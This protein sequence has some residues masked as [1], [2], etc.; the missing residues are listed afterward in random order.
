MIAN[1]R[2]YSV[3]AE[4]KA[5]WRTLLAWVIARAG[6]ALEIIDYDPPAPMAALWAR[7]DLGCAM[8]CGLPASL[9]VPAPRL[10]AAPVPSPSRYRGQACYMTDIAVR[11]DSS[12]GSLEDTFGGI[13]GFTVADSQS[14]YFALRYHLWPLQRQHGGA[15]Y[16]SAIGGLLN[17]RGVIDAL[18]AGTIDVGPLDSYSHDLLRHLEP[19]YAQQVRI[20]ASSAATPMPPFV[21]T[22]DLDDDAIELLRTAFRAA[23]QHD[24]LAGTRAQLLLAGFAFPQ[25]ADYVP[26]RQ[27]RDALIAAPEL[28]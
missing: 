28:W 15:L 23:A 20:V 9:R 13:V 14:G 12:F 2:M 24:D 27:R 11:A 18:V 22:A 7:D 17:A 21:A 25:P 19:D 8:M 16:R 1:A 6:L 3:N 4:A 5:A 10:I 26:L